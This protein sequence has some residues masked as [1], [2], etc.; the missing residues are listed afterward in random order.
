MWVAVADLPGVCWARVRALCG[1]RLVHPSAG[2]DPRA[3]LGGG[4]ALR[5]EVVAATAIAAAVPELERV[6]EADAAGGAAADLA[7]G[8]LG[9]VACSAG[10]VGLRADVVV[11]HRDACVE[12]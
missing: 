12:K 10:R 9:E 8:R 3:D 5:L 7:A 4:E 11:A 6:A 1:I 2:V